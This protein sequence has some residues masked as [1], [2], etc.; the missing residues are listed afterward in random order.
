MAL[1]VGNQGAV[2]ASNYEVYQGVL[3]NSV[4]V[5]GVAGTLT[6]SGNLPLI[7][8]NHRDYL[9]F[10]N[11]ISTTSSMGAGWF[12][13]E[14]ASGNVEKWD[15]IYTYKP[16]SGKVHD[17]Y[18]L[19][20]SSTS[21][22][23][24]VRQSTSSS[25]TS[26]NA[27]TY[28]GS[29]TVNFGTGSTAAQAATVMARANEAYV[30]GTS[31][32]PGVFDQL[33]YRYWSGSTLASDYFSLNV[34]QYKCWDTNN[35]SFQSVSYRLDRLAEYSPG[36]APLYDKVQTGPRPSTMPDDC[37]PETPVWTQYGE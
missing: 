36:S 4:T 27:I 17:L 20:P 13:T 3:P 5:A 18:T 7:G 30:S 23:A 28:S 9:I 2:F 14:D 19:I 8:S 1:L 32:M 26:W 33:K 21:F 6:T 16:S 12:G 11:F 29:K 15:L 24:H 35:S 31:D 25:S 37:D 10:T 22:T 34:N